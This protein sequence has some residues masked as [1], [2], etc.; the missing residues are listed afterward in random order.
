MIQTNKVKLKG[1]CRYS[2]NLKGLL[3][4]TLVTGSFMVIQ[5]E[6]IPRRGNIRYYIR[7]YI[8]GVHSKHHAILTVSFLIDS[9]EHYGSPHLS[10]DQ[11]TVPT[12]NSEP[13]YTEAAALVT[14]SFTYA[15]HRSCRLGFPPLGGARC[16]AFLLITAGSTSPSSIDLV[17]QINTG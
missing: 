15:P 7:S 11:F 1:N 12:L 14:S 13:K 10:G 2:R 16:G 6:A 4:W 5:I 3:K 8:R 17:L 9:E